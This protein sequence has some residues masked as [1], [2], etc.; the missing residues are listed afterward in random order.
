MIG[1]VMF[2]MHYEFSPLAIPLLV[3]ILRMMSLLGRTAACETAAKPDLIIHHKDRTGMMERLNIFLY[4]KTLPK[5]L[6]SH[7]FQIHHP[8]QTSTD[9]PTLL[10]WSEGSVR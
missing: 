1:G 9:L 4:R 2:E 10:L 8:Y 3:R 6:V 7:L 5:R